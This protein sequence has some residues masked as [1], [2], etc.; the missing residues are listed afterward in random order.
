MVDNK[1]GV[2]IQGPLVLLLRSADME[3]IKEVNT[4]PTQWNTHSVKQRTWFESIGT[5]WQKF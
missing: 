4:L 3:V 2:Q 1:K 5:Q